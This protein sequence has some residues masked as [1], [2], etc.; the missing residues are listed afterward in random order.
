MEELGVLFI[1]ASGLTSLD[2]T[3]HSTEVNLHLSAGL[4]RHHII[5]TY[6]H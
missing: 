5:V 4:R 6:P 3:V 2:L 1:F